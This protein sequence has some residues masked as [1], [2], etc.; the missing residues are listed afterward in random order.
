M[1]DQELTPLDRE[2][3]ALCDLLQ[4]RIFRIHAGELLADALELEALGL[5]S[6]GLFPHESLDAQITRAAHWEWVAGIS[7]RGT[8]AWGLRFNRCGLPEGDKPCRDE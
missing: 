7:E 3:I 5:P 8:V 6:E 2:R 1:R 4:G